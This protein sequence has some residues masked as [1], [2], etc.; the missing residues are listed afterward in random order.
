MRLLPNSRLCGTMLFV[1]LLYYNDRRPTSES[2]V[3]TLPKRLSAPTAG[4]ATLWGVPP[5][6]LA[7]TGDVRDKRA[8]R[9]CCT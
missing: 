1:W 9:R 6:P 7:S 2:A 3:G 5:D 8:T 4:C